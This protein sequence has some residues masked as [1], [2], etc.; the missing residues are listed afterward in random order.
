MKANDKVTSKNATLS[1]LLSGILLGFFV[2]GLIGAGGIVYLI[3]SAA[4]TTT[5]ATS[6]EHEPTPQ[7]WALA[8]RILAQERAED[9]DG[10]RL[11]ESY[12]DAPKWKQDEIDGAV[13]KLYRETGQE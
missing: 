4:A 7:E 3:R 2:V 9:P 6:E 1:I 13:H 11:L 5:I 10:E 8:N 12:R